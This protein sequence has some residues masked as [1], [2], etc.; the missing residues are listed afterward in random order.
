MKNK[1]LVAIPTFNYKIMGASLAAVLHAKR[2]PETHV[3]FSVTGFSGLT[4]NFNNQFVDALNG[5]KTGLTHFAM[6]HDDID[7]EAFWLDKLLEIMENWNADIVSAISP[8]KDDRGLT[9]TARENPDNLWY[10]IRYTM[11][12]LAELPPTFSRPDLLLNTGLML[13]DMRK[14]WVKKI[15]FHVEDEINEVAPG[16]FRANF[17][18]EDWLFSRDAALMGAKVVATREVK[19]KHCGN[20][21]FPNTGAWG[22]EAFDDVE[23]RKNLGKAMSPVE[24]N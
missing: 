17:M 10:P 12:E 21:F 20:S 7:P 16:E 2:N 14:P 11:R 23:R 15:R 13:V 5:L 8:I 4:A 24:P 1:V 9:S 6:I 3:D 22:T 19:L 18:S